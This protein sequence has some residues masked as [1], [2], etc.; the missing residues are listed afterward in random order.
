[1]E[2]RYIR[3]KRVMDII[4]ALAGIALLGALLPLLFVLIRFDGGP[5]F[6]TQ[7]RVG[8]GHRLFR[9]Y[10]LRTM[11]VDAEWIAQRY[12][13]THKAFIQREND[14]RVTRVGRVLRALSIDELPQLYNVLRGDMSLIGPRPL[15]LAES[16]LLPSRALARYNVR[17]GLSGPAQLR[18]RG[19]AD[20]HQRADADVYYVQNISFMLDLKL[21]LGTFAAVFRQDGV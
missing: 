11:R 19:K 6:F 2:N 8:R 9:C 21:L 1:M 17:P 15:V 7:T 20:E 3:F 5:L 13:S 14:P 10:K 4:A 18:E 12:F 16:N